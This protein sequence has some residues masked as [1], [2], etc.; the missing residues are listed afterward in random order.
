[1]SPNV[2]LIIIRKCPVPSQLLYVLTVFFLYIEH[3]YVDK[4]FSDYNFVM[5]FIQYESD[6]KQLNPVSNPISGHIIT[7]YEVY[8]VFSQL[9]ELGG[10]VRRE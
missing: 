1:M 7:E 3:V 2:Y 8:R 5:Y 6:P 9:R 4:D 10:F